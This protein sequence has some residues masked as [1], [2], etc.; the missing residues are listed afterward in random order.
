MAETTVQA[1]ANDTATP[2]ETTR[3]QDRYIAP[4]VDIYEE[5]GGLR[6]VADLPGSD[7]NEINVR[8]DQGVLTIQA[9][10]RHLMDREPTHAEFRLANFFRQFQLPE[11]VDVDGISADVQQGVLKLWLPWAPE[12]Q[13]R[14]INVR[15]G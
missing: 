15:V 10:T 4:P 14:K 9:A 8:V 12:T 6:V 11:K 13:P 5:K 1:P 2:Q 7:P 3:A